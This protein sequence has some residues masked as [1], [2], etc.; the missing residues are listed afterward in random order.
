MS[1]SFPSSPTDGQRYTPAGG[2]TYEWSAAKSAWV[3][4]ASSNIINRQVY[5]ATSGQTTVNIGYTPGYVDVFLNG[6]KLTNGVDFTASD[7]S[8]ITLTDACAAGDVLDVVAFSIF[9]LADIYT[10][11]QSDLRYYVGPGSVTFRAVNSVPTGWL[12]ANGAAISRTTYVDLYNAIGTAYGTGDGSTTFNIPDL[13]GEFLRGWDDSRGVDSGRAL[14]SAQ[15]AMIG[16]HTHTQT[17]DNIYAS[18]TGRSGPS[19]TGSQY[20]NISTSTGTDTRPRNIALL[21]LIK[22]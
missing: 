17:V 1:M 20:G 14:G 9:S 2:V 3:G 15:S 19:S 22:Y 5:T 6:F 11:S 18:G 12:K 4:V 16:P 10:Q 7:G 13:R 8:V 21:A